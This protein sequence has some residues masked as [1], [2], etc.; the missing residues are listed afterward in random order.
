MLK[1]YRNRKGYKNNTLVGVRIRQR[2]SLMVLIWGDQ[3]QTVAL[4]SR[5][6]TG[7]DSKVPWN[8]ENYLLIVLC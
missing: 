3:K 8:N 5:Q 1:C 4:A 6:E 2:K 7:S